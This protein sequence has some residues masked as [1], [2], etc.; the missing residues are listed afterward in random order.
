[1]GN[2]GEAR[3]DVVAMGR[4]E[5][6][7]VMNK[8]SAELD[9]LKA[10]LAG[11]EKAQ[12]AAG[13]GS[14]QAAEGA[15]GLGAALGDLKSKAE[16]VNK[17]REAFEN[18]KGNFGFVVA[19]AAGV[20]GAIVALT[21]AFD[22]SR[23][24]VNA[25]SEFQKGL[26]AILEK[27]RDIIE[28][29]QILLG[30]TS[31]RTEI[32]KSVEKLAASWEVLNDQVDNGEAKIKSYDDE[33][34]RLRSV[35]FGMLELS[36]AFQQAERDL[37]NARNDHANVLKQR[38]AL[39]KEHR[40]ALEASK[41]EA[42][43]L[44]AAEMELLDA[45][46]KVPFFQQ[47]PA[48]PANDDTPVMLR[49]PPE[50]KPKPRGGGGPRVDE[51]KRMLEQQQKALKRQREEL[52]AEANREWDE[53]FGV[54]AANMLRGELV[55]R[56]DMAK[57][58]EEKAKEEIARKEQEAAGRLKGDKYTNTLTASLADFNSVGRETADVFAMIAESGQGLE[59]VLPGLV[60]AFSSISDIWA[61]TDGSAKS[62]AQGVLGSVDAVATAGAA[63]FKDE[64]AR[65][66]FLGIKEMLLSA[67]LAF[68]DPAQAAVKFATGAALVALAGGG[69]GG[70]GGGGRSSSGGSAG[71]VPDSPRG[72]GGGTTIWNV[73]TLVADPHTLQRANASSTRAVSGTGISERSAA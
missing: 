34:K 11:Y 72:D 42:G 66:R 71:Y 31:E 65:T 57:Q 5:V 55:K 40:D 37:A 59:A 20:V 36:P 12:K 26:P 56:Q 10:K 53:L 33:L 17:V 61:A 73:N 28:E 54:D 16:P 63:W 51:W 41:V 6:T 1:M 50:D 38:T 29:V 13:Q 7:V 8:V 15:K 70:G 4:D 22:R 60:G 45:R 23:A 25:F 69:G 46:S 14:T 9:A 62:M 39:E 3:L 68:I 27:N 48:K 58:Q 2:A 21:E 43:K 30:K 64:K 44:F 32:G 19:G 47:Y 52:I 24:S 49:P 18:L 67:P 35:A